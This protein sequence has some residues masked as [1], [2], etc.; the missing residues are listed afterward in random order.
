MHD[1]YDELA[2]KHD[3][4]ASTNLLFFAEDVAELTAKDI[5]KSNAENSKNFALNHW[6]SDYP[7]GMN[8]E[9]IIDSLLNPDTSSH[10]DNIVP[11]Q[12]VEDLPPQRLAD[13]IVGTQQ[14]CKEYMDFATDMHIVRD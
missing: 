7:D 11:W 6:L 9:Q 12:V 14:A 1:T 3:L 4:Y 10:V 5:K 13:I 2:K 8:Y